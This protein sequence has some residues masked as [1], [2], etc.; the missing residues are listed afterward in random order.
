MESVQHQHENNRDHRNSLTFNR[1][2]AAKQLQIS[3]SWLD[4]LV[5]NGKIGHC[6]TGRRVLFCTE[7]LVQY[8]KTIQ[9]NVKAG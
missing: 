3:T 2:Q 9:R 4:Q 1:A 7:H 6:R 5:R 8:L